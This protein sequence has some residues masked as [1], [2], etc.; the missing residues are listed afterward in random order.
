[1]G[2]ISAPAEIEEETAADLPTLDRDLMALPPD[3]TLSEYVTAWAKRSA[4]GESGVLPV[5]A[6]LIVIIIIFQVER[7]ASSPR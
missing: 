1:V 7:R 3:A 6:G 4:A 5:V 2:E